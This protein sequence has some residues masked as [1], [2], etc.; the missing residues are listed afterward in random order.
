MTLPNELALTQPYLGHRHHDLGYC[1]HNIGCCLHDIGNCR[2][3]NTLAT[4]ASVV[5]TT[6]AIAVVVE[7]GCNY[8]VQSVAQHCDGEAQGQ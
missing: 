6:S 2:D 1:D 7:E 8:V 4:A 3:H 5:A